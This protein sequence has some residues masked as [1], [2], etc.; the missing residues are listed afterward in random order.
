MNGYV[1]KI[2]GEG[3][4]AKYAFVGLDRITGDITTYHVKYAKQTM[5]KS[6]GFIE[7]P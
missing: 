4:S 2:G 6:P 7:T 3:K 5:K 1:I